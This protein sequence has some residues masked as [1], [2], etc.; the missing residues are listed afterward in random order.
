MRLQL[1]NAGRAWLLALG[2]FA[3]AAVAQAQDRID[4]A[5]QAETRTFGT[6]PISHTL[7]AFAFHGLQPDLVNYTTNRSRFC[8]MSGCVYEAPVQLPAGAVITQIALEACDTNPSGRLEADL[9]RVGLPDGVP[10]LHARATTGDN[11]ATPGCGVFQAALSPHL[12]VDNFNDVY[13]IHVNIFGDNSMTRFLAVRVMY[14]LQVSV[15]PAA[16][17][18]NDVPP[19]HPFFRFIEALV[20]AGVTSGCSVSPPLYCP[21][22]P[23][24]RGQMAVFLSRALG[25]HFSP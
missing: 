21:D 20:D 23:V 14:T 19:G 17:T 1:R 15:G 7:P 18:F 4:I 6:P 16:A 2:L 3:S 9:W 11:S 22:Q 10:A 8:T 25:L 5:R 13:F 12:I 24:T